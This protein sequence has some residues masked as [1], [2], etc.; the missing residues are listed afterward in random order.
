MLLSSRCHMLVD[1]TPRENARA[2]AVGGGRQTTENAPIRQCTS[3]P[4][5]VL[6]DYFQGGFPCEAS[7][8][9][10]FDNF[11]RFRDSSRTKWLAIRDSLLPW[12]KFRTGTSPSSDLLVHA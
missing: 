10:G 3:G 9:Q 2:L 4:S 5:V 6:A 11:L 12:P 8:S 7:P 1:N